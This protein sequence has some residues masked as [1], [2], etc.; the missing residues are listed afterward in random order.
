MLLKNTMKCKDIITILEQ[1]WPVECALSW[2]NVGL[3]V[4]S[5]EKEV[6]RIL[7]TLDL[8]DDVLTQAI[9]MKADMIISH[10]PLIFSTLKRITDGNFIERRIIS[11]IQH[12]ISYYAMHTNFDVMGMG[13]L[14]GEALGLLNDQVL[15]ETV[16]GEAEGI[17]RIG[18]ISG[19]Q[20]LADFARFVKAQLKIPQVQVYGDD[21][22]R[23]SRV[24]VSGGSGKSMIASAVNARADV[25]VT[26]DMDH[27]T[28]IDAVA[29]GLAVIDAGHY[30][31]EYMFMDYVKKQME[32]ELPGVE[33]TTAQTKVPF[34]VV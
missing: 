17:G 34:W 1:K 29:Q 18:S 15:W 20:E 4:G 16:E 2:D 33:I 26:G 12:D 8:T 5:Q 23:I 27:H 13:R 25:L 10:H 7:I 11:L 14:N 6:I 9:E 3:L 22:K 30:G 24:A 19:E 21:H 31:T 28:G 32:K